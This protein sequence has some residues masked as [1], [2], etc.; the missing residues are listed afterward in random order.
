MF[1][2]S[3]YDLQH[4]MDQKIIQKES[5]EPGRCITA[6]KLLCKFGKESNNILAV[7]MSEKPR[8]KQNH[9]GQGKKLHPVS[10][11]NTVPPPRDKVIATI[12]NGLLKTNS[13]ADSSTSRK[14][15]PDS[16]TSRKKKLPD[17]ST[18]RKKLKE[19]AS[20]KKK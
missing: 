10:S 19:E 12:V 11:F 4:K 9:P 15:L 7:D 16:S 13:S 2:Y 18:S 20:R 14:K 17:S 8:G 1:N 6:N 3:P 5:E